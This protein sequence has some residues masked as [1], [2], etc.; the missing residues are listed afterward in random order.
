MS[1][2]GP[3]G[4]K[5]QKVRTDNVS[6]DAVLAE[7]N[8]IANSFPPTV[9]VAAKCTDGDFIFVGSYEGRGGQE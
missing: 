8:S 7:L 6:S 5:W 4:D 9:A 3:H 2:G 1:N